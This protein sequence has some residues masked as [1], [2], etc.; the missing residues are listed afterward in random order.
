MLMDVIYF[1]LA[2]FTS[3]LELQ[4]NHRLGHRMS[5][6]GHLACLSPFKHVGPSTLKFHIVISPNLKILEID[7]ERFS[8]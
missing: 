8:N 3:D 2:S 4:A 6:Q 1:G 5:C 7:G